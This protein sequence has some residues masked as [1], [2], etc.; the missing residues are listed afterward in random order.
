MRDAG[1]IQERLAKLEAL[2]SRGATAGE[3][4]AA[5]AARGDRGHDL[6]AVAKA[7]G[8]RFPNAECGRSSL[9]STLHSVIRWRASA[10]D[11]NEEP[12]RH[13]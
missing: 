12:F 5:G 7:L 8:V 4:A 3:R 2:F 9:W 13:S 11:R 6:R 1:D 10:I